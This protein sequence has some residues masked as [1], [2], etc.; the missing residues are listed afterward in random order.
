MWRDDPFA[1][2]AGEENVLRAKLRQEVSSAFS[3]LGSGI[4]ISF[5]KVLPEIQFDYLVLGKGE[6]RGISPR[7]FF[8]AARSNEDV[9]LDLESVDFLFVFTWDFIIQRWMD[10]GL[11][12]IDSQE[13]IIGAVYVS[14]GGITEHGGKI[15]LIRFDEDAMLLQNR[16]MHES[17]HLLGLADKDKVLCKFSLTIMCWPVKPQ[18][19]IGDEIKIRLNE[20]IAEKPLP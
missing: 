19:E 17:G 12:E 15:S 8:L 3:R 5:V 20:Y 13:S 10:S 16:I 4:D 18:M 6:I 14:L 2:K 1:V 7:S 11:V 9:L